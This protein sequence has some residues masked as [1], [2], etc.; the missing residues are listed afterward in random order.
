MRLGFPASCCALLLGSCCLVSLACAGRANV[1]SGQGGSSGVAGSST[2][3]GTT[4]F[5]P[6]VA[7][8][9]TPATLGASPVKCCG[10]VTPEPP[11]VRACVLSAGCSPGTQPTA[12]S[13]CIAQALP[14][15]VAFPDCVI[16]AQSCAEMAV[17]L[18]TGFYPDA[19]EPDQLGTRCVGTKVVHCVDVG[20]RFFVDCKKTGALCA[21]FSD[22]D[23]DVLDSAGC[24]V[25]PS[26]TAASDVYACS[27]TKRFVCQHGIGFGEDC[28]ARD[29]DCVNKPGGAIC[30]HKLSS[31]ATPGVGK[32][33]AAGKT[34]SF[35]QADGQAL[36][37]DCGRLGFT[38]QEAPDRP[39][40][41]ACVNPACPAADAAQCLEEC[42]GPLAHLC[43]G[44]QRFSVD[45]QS[46]GFRGCI[47]ETRPGD[48]DR[49]RC[50]DF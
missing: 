22:K 46:Y 34:G 13:D 50:G 48:G 4:T 17:C 11:L 3:A 37:I 5:L 44:G 36:A 20:P 39:Q 1:S 29:L 43:L 2:T 33:D 18:G 47:L 7:A 8:T 32:C 16:G 6:P 49:A 15:S 21:P 30:A 26:C 27:G 14:D 23:N 12:L 41:I 31:C 19:C 28:A 25:V 42:D 40:G 38:C 45:C 35:C 10:A 24:A 9:G